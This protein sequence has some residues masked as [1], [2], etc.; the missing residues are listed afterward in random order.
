M[1]VVDQYDS[2]N[3]ICCTLL[4]LRVKGF[5][6]MSVSMPTLKTL[7]YDLLLCWGF[8]FPRMQHFPLL[9]VQTSEA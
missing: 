6:V 9:S 5:R 3:L 1:T 8:F 4:L 7:S 2:S